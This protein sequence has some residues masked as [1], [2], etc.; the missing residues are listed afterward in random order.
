MI[1]LPLAGSARRRSLRL[2]GLW[3]GVA[4]AC[5]DGGA[6]GSSSISEAEATAKQLGLAATV[7]SAPLLRPDFELTDG[8][9][10][11]FDF[12]RATGG[13]LTVLF[14]GYTSCPDICPATLA[15]LSAGLRDL[16]ADVRDEVTVVFVGVDPQR[17][18]RERVRDWLARFDPRFVGLTG[19]EAEIA[20]AEAA[21]AVP[22]AFVDERFADGYSV[23]HASF[24]LVYTQDDRAH[25][26]YGAETSAAQW[27]HDL[28]VLARDGWPA[29]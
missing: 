13:R 29:A 11:P 14:F 27:A 10:R 18:T 6:A 25:L 2:A 19:S 9:G 7:L 20:R 17:D 1:A 28:G 8:E 23:A 16:P 5:G 15:S 4:L 12:R 26:R 3:V 24:A 21:A 22:P